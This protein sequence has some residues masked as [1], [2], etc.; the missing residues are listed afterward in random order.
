MTVCRWNWLFGV[1]AAESPPVGDNNTQAE[2]SESLAETDDAHKKKKKRVG[3]RDRR[4]RM[5]WCF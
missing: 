4:V 3:F 1:D 5:L 2:E